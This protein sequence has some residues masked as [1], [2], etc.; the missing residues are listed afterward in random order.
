MLTIRVMTRADMAVTPGR[1]P[2]TRKDRSHQKIPHSWPGNCCS[3]EL[4]ATNQANA[5][6]T[7]T[8]KRECANGICGQ[9]KYYGGRG[10]SHYGVS[11]RGPLTTISR[12]IP[13][14]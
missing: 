3:P 13:A 6:Q 8:I 11:F 7:V 4:L 1:K 2:D 10:V 12:P 9:S 5:Q 14:T